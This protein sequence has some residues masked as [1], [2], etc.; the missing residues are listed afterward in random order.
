MRGLRPTIF[1]ACSCFV[2]VASADQGTP[3][4]TPKD[5]LS[6]QGSEIDAPT[7]IKM[8]M[9]MDEPMEGG[10]MQKGMMK[11]DV[12][13]SAEKKEKEMEELLKKEEESM[14]PMPAQT[15]RGDPGQ[16]TINPQ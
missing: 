4:E 10:M 3:P 13:A 14:P 9:K 2:W 15:P 6:Q 5:A 12:K 11:G 1:M 7:I 16:T 8:P